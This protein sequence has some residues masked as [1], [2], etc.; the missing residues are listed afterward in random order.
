M[1][2]IVSD[3]VSLYPFKV[4][5]DRPWFLMMRRSPGTVLEGTWQG[6]HGRLIEGENASRGAVRE[7]LEKT[8]LNI[9]ALWSVDFV[10]TYHDP[11]D[12]TIV[13][14]PCF[15]AL[16]E[17]EVELSDGHDASRWHSHREAINLVTFEHQ[18]SALEIANKM[19]AHP[20]AM[21][22]NPHACFSIV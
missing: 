14:A 18:R 5:Q 22:T 15:V 7:L 2:S 16:V 1:S 20:V 17:G 6:V 21:G 9:K 12:D 19:I 13:L 8:G 4:E 10:E 11:R 3:S